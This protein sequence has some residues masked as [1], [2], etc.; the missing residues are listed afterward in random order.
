MLQVSQLPQAQ[1][2]DGRLCWEIFKR[3]AVLLRLRRS[4]ELRFEI[5]VEHKSGVAATLQLAQLSAPRPL[6]LVE[7]WPMR[8]LWHFRNG[9]KKL[10]EAMTRV[11]TMTGK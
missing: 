4:T 10:A 8:S 2:L 6:P 7:A 11:T 3:L 9:K 5:A 1:I